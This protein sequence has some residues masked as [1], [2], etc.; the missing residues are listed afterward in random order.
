MT[1]CKKQRFL[2]QELDGRKVEVEFQGAGI[3]PAMEEG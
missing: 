1:E 3:S 2:F